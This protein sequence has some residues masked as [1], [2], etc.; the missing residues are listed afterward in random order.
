MIFYF[1]KKDSHGCILNKNN[2]ADFA[3]R[4]I[5]AIKR[6][7]HDDN[8]SIKF[9]AKILAESMEVS[10]QICRRYLRGDARPDHDKVLKLAHLLRVSP[11][12]LL[13]GEENNTFIT[14]KNTVNIDI[15]LLRYILEKSHALFILDPDNAD[16][17]PDFVLALVNDI[18]MIHTDTETLKK[19]I[20]L[21]VG[22]ISSFEE[23]KN[24]K[25]AAQI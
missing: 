24:K 17:Y 18:N 19:I 15:T 22:S 23:R 14:K 12:W 11:G 13:F 2:C 25:K 20:D 7:E 21:A 6:R 9:S 5:T 4:L 8:V 3:E 1:N 10:E 16:D